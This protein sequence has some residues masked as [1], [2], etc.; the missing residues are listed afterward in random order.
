MSRHQVISLQFEG[1]AQQDFKLKDLVTD[2]AGVRSPA[3]EV[4]IT[5]TID[6]LLFELF[7]KV[8]D[9]ERDFEKFSNA[10]RIINIVKGTTGTEALAV[11][12][13]KLGVVPDLHRHTDHLTTLLFEQSRSDRRI[14]PTTHGNDNFF[15]RFNHN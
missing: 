1:T 3:V 11:L 10:A 8:N 15:T 7:F 2:N 14:D 13:G 12:I 4:V 5:E 6:N 9:V